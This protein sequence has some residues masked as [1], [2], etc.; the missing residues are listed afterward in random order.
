MGSPVTRADIRNAA[1]RR[2]DQVNS[3]FRTDSDINA[4]INQTLKEVY[5]HII[6]QQ[7]ER[8][9][10]ST[11]FTT[12]SGQSTYPLPADTYKVKSV[13]ATFPGYQEP[14]ELDMFQW[15]NRNRYTGPGWDAN[16]PAA[17][18]LYGDN[19][20]FTPLPSSA[21]PVTVW[22][23]PGP[24]ELSSD[25]DTFDG[26]AGWDEA[27]VVGVAWKLSLEEAD[28]ELS[29]RLAGEYQRQLKRVL[30]FAPVRVTEHTEQARDVYQRDDVRWW[31]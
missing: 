15:E 12:N 2:A 13:E 20:V 9:L 1:R 26:V 29:D 19:V 23:H 8:Y 5:E 30:D 31:P 14:R 21:V 22:Y 11:A 4:L 24:P 10:S 16:T 17:W 6:I 18:R 28:L 7:P 27:I 25:S 3:E